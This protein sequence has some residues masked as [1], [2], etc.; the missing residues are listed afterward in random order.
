M[1]MNSIA[2]MLVLWLTFASARK[3]YDENIARWS[4][5]IF[6]FATFAPTYV[7]AIWPH[8]VA[9]SFWMG[10]VYL[11]ISAHHTF[12]RK[13]GTRA[14]L[15][16]GLLV[17]LGLNI[18]VDV[19]LAGLIIFFWLRLFAKPHDRIAPLFVALGMVPGLLLS[20]WLNQIK[21]GAFSPFSYGDVGGAAGVSRYAP[22]A[23]FAGV[24]ITVSWTVNV[25]SMLR[26][27]ISKPVR[28][29]SAFAAFLVISAM[30][31][32]TPIRDLLWRVLTGLYVLVINLQAHE[33]YHQVGVEKNAY[34]QLLFWGYPKKALIQSIPWLALAAVPCINALREKTFS[35]VGLCFFAIAAPLCFYALNHWH[36]GGSYNMRY[37]LPALPFLAMLSANGLAQVLGDRPVTRQAALAVFVT[38]GALYLG[39]QEFGQHSERFYVPAALYPQWLI[40]LLLGG[41]IAWRHFQSTPAVTKLTCVLGLFALAYAS[42]I[43]LYEEIGHERTRAEQLTRAND[44]SAALPP[45]SLVITPM[46]TSLI[47][48]EKRGVFVMAVNEETAAHAA[49]AAY[50]FSKAGRCVYFHNSLPVKLVSPFL[51]RP[52]ATE[53]V[54][55]QSLHFADDPRLAFFLLAGTPAECRVFSN[56]PGSSGIIQ[57]S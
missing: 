52:I 44:I 46:Q 33:A 30:I 31:A 41:A 34:G 47:P 9:L 35:N 25:P 32:I 22:I 1:L 37:F 19:F 45:G 18:R 15:C 49:A 17:G 54:W 38:A 24:L 55:A 14:L 26:G 57:N 6:A 11:A 53:P 51:A 56:E 12:S 27:A 20:A 28:N 36:G 4:V 2:F 21:F 42:V 8:M 29:Y 5:G 7:F 10:A 3:L 50:A 23:A 13:T 43:N 48:A 39:F 40:A 16:A